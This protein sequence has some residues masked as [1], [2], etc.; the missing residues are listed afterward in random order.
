MIIKGDCIEEMSKKEQNK[1]SKILN[2]LKRYFVVGLLIGFLILG[3]Y[4][5]KSYK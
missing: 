2:E 5:L 3:I 1:I 4:L